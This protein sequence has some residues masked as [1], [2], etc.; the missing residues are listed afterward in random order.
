MARETETWWTGNYARYSLRNL[1]SMPVYASFKSVKGHYSRTDGDRT[2]SYWTVDNCNI[3]EWFIQGQNKGEKIGYDGWGKTWFYELWTPEVDHHLTVKTWLKANAEWGLIIR[4]YPTKEISER[5]TLDKGVKTLEVTEVEGTQIKTHRTGVKPLAD[6]VD[7]W[8]ADTTESPGES[9]YEIKW[10]RPAARGGETRSQR[11]PLTS[12]RAWFESGADNEE[13]IWNEDS[14]HQWGSVKGQKG[15]QH[16]EH[17]WDLEG[18]KRRETH[19]Y[20]EGSR[21]WGSKQRVE[22][23]KWHKEE[24]EGLRPGPSGPAPDYTRRLLANYEEARN[25][26]LE[27]ETTLDSMVDAEHQAVLD[28][29]KAQRTG[30]PTPAAD[31]P[32]EIIRT[33]TRAHQLLAEHERM[34]RAL[35]AKPTT[36]APA[37]APAEDFS[38]LLHTLQGLV[39]AHHTHLRQ[40]TDSRVSDD[41]LRQQATTLEHKRD[42]VRGPLSKALLEETAGLLREQTGLKQEFVEKLLKEAPPAAAKAQPAGVDPAV[43]QQLK[44]EYAG[45]VANYMETLYNVMLQ[46]D[47]VCD[48][49]V[50]ALK[51]EET[52]AKLDEFE[53][54]FGRIHDEYDETKD[55]A[56]LG[57]MLNLLLQYQ[58]IN[59]DMAGRLHNLDPDQTKKDLAHKGVSMGAQRAKVRSGRPATSAFDQF[60]AKVDASLGYTATTLR[61]LAGDEEGAVKTEGGLELTGDPISTIDAKLDVLCEALETLSKMEISED[62]STTE[63]S[64]QETTKE[65]THIIQIAAKDDQIASMTKEIAKRETRMRE[66][67]NELEELRADSRAFKQLKADFQMV[68]AEKEKLQKELKALRS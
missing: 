34:K 43:V 52:K 35:L 20:D 17:S 66:M 64:Q 5:W 9:D 11:G 21:N 40:L 62:I 28:S 60:A 56:K 27:S 24:W 26:L 29:L 53:S 7:E 49:L 46:N 38:N 39:A 67:N 54:E 4:R 18:P 48:T 15:S 63:T 55:P 6:G 45:S 36:A 2:E 57:E 1:N 33:I 65:E 47:S 41:H 25:A 59:Y 61:G 19:D 58:P 13:K 30:L 22:G 3:F 37:A 8:T 51:D 12:G 44:E 14:G 32:E 10:A 50:E 68:S 16:Y 31:N 23:E 42:T